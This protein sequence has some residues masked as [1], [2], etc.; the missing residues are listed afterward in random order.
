MEYYSQPWIGQDVFV[1]ET[2]KFKKDGFFVDIGCHDYKNISNT[3]FFEKELN[4]KGLAVDRE[5]VFKQ[6]W[7]KYRPNSHFVCQDATTVDYQSVLDS[8]QAPKIIDYLT[9]DTEPPIV[10]LKSL[11]KVLDTDYTFRVITFETDHYTGDHSAKDPSRKILQEKGYTFIKS[12][13]D[14]D[15]YWINYNVL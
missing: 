15:D 11:L 5:S 14:Q 2:L 10:S 7:E 8:I 9:V 13:N 6:D 12:I 3:Y 4:W 1:A